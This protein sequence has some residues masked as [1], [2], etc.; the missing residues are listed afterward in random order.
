MDRSKCLPLNIR[1]SAPVT[2][3]TVAE[4]LEQNLATDPPDVV[5]NDRVVNP[6][7]TCD[8]T[9]GCGA[10]GGG[11]YDILT[12]DTRANSQLPG[13]QMMVRPAHR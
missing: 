12:R 13:L 8:L 1:V 11:N 3:V 2:G 9:F 5:S 4:T 6:D 7:F 10:D